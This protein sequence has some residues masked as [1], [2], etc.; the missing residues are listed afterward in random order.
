MSHTGRW[1]PVKFWGPLGAAYP[2]PQLYLIFIPIF[3]PS[4]QVRRKTG[5]FPSVF[6]WAS[7]Y[8]ILIPLYFLYI[9]LYV[10]EFSH[11]FQHDHSCYNNAHT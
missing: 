9:V 7:M 10:V 3:T 8:S 4:S 2:V 6:A 5:R 11:T 1:L